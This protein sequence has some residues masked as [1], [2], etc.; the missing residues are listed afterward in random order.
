MTWWTNFT[1]KMMLKHFLF[2]AIKE[3]DKEFR[4]RINKSSFKC[5][6]QDHLYCCNYFELS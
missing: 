4:L 6:L 3:A 1:N 5:Q 2:I